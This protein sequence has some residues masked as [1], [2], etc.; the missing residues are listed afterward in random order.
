MA[1]SGVGERLAEPERFAPAL[2]Y[3]LELAHGDDR[4]T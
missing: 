3:R 2:H 4:L 1:D